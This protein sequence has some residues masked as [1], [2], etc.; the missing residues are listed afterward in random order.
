MELNNLPKITKK[1][2]KRIGR[3]HGS[4]KVKTAGRGTKGQK[5][6]GSIKK[7]FEGGQLPLIKRLPLKRGKDKNNPLNKKPIII[8]V[9]FLNLLKPDSIVDIKTLIS[10]GLIKKEQSEN[11][12]VKILGEGEIKIPLIIKLPCSHG[13]EEK[14]KKA[15]G[16]IERS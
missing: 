15:G 7:T 8:N 6:R 4:G 3:G 10:N 5:A 2:K 16:K 14:I 12:K 1:H 11:I 9:K 13:A